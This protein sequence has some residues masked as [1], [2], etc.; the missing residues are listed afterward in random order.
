MEPYI[1][2]LVVGIALAILEIII[3][4]FMAIF[5]SIGAIKFRVS[6]LFWRILFLNLKS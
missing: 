2:W 1:A 4:V 3:P 5:L 6:L